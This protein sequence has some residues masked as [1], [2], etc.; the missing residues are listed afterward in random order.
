MKV[1]KII[2][3]VCAFCLFSIAMNKLV[4]F[5][6]WDIPGS[7]LGVVLLFALL[8]AKIIRLEW[9]EVGG[10]W[11]LGELLLFFIPSA[12]GIVQYKE[13]LMSNGVFILIAI[14]LGT[15][16]VMAFT[17]VLADKIAGKKGENRI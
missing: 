16:I 7:I 8:Q 9:V 2:A 13:F 12:V 1:I 3:Q 14:I 15:M 17:G 11:L 10:N 5:L 4:E 6:H